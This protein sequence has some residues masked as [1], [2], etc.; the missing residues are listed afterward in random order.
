MPTLP[1][2]ALWEKHLSEP[3]P[4]GLVAEEVDGL[5]V[6]ILDA[7]ASGCIAHFLAHDGQLDVR[8][9]A[10]LGLTYRHLA[11]VARALE[12]AGQDYF[13][14]LEDLAHEVLQSVRDSAAEE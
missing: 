10:M 7:V 2:H 14:R 13:L 6:S 3:F 11:V 4:A 1:I 9:T 5:N 8:R 12:G